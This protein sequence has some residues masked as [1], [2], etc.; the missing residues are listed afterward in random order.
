MT[1]MPKQFLDLCLIYE[2][3]DTPGRWV[4]HS[5]NTDHVAT[6]NNVI[7]AMMALGRVLDALFSAARQ[8]PKIRVFSPAP[9][10]IRNRVMHARPLPLELLEI[11]EL[12]RQGHRARQPERE[13]YGGRFDAL[14]APLEV[15]AV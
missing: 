9:A 15:A 5:L 3:E 1:S 10:E 14:Q 7:S 13:P 8:D 6:G 12:K 4:A 2:D 11:L